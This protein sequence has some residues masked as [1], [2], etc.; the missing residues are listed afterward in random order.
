MKKTV[1]H[2]GNELQ[3]TNSSTMEMPLYLGQF[4]LELRLIPMNLKKFNISHYLT[5][6]QEAWE[7]PG[8]WS[9]DRLPLVKG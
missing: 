9:K 7:V 6:T 4:N 3:S 1:E 5:R 8:K 2:S